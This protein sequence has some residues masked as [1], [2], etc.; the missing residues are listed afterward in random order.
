MQNLHGSAIILIQQL[1]FKLSSL[2]SL[3]QYTV[4]QHYNV[5]RGH[6]VL[7]SI[8]SLHWSIQ[9]ITTKNCSV[10][11][12]V[13]DVRFQVTEWLWHRAILKVVCYCWKM[14]PRQQ[15]LDVT[16]SMSNYYKSQRQAREG[17]KTPHP[18]RRSS[19]QFKPPVISQKGPCNCCAFTRRWFSLVLVRRAPYLQ[20]PSLL[21]S[22]NNFAL[23]VKEALLTFSY[24]NSLHKLA[25]FAFRCS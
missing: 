19:L 8:I 16:H 23:K 9:S 17:L 1:F 2:F 21:F 14:R 15:L 7:S 13:R 12:M 18:L 5:N 20:R 10:G 11:C 4:I 22:E 24:F 3:L 6:V 25:V